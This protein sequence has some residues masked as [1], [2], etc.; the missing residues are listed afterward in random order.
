MC[1]HAQSIPIVFRQQNNKKKYNYV[2]DNQCL[3]NEDSYMYTL[4]FDTTYNPQHVLFKNK[5]VQ[6]VLTTNI[7]YIMKL[8]KTII[9]QY[10]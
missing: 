7:F 10:T 8:L 1:A 2:Q 9:L 4:Q 6:K 5:G 3:S